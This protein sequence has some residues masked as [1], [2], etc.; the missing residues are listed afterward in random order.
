MFEDPWSWLILIIILA[1]GG[2][3]SLAETAFAAADPIRIKVLSEKSSLAKKTLHLIE[4]FDDSVIVTVIGSN[5][6]SV[7]L[8]TI[9]TIFFITLYQDDSIGTI[10][11]TIFSS[12]LFYIFCDTI[13]KVIGRGLPNQSAL[14]S[15][16]LFQIFKVIFFPIYFILSRIKK[17][18]N[19]STK[20]TS[21]PTMTEA[22][23]ANIV[24]QQ[25]EEGTLDEH[26]VK[27]IQSAI[28]FSDTTVKD[29]LTPI[30]Q[31]SGLP[32]SILH[33]ADLANHL[34]NSPFSRI[35]IYRD[36]LQHIIGVLSIRTY[37]QNFQ[38]NRQVD[39]VL[40]MKKPYFVTSKV[41][42]DD[43]FEGYKKFRTHVAIV[44]DQL[45]HV[46]GMVTMEDVLEEIVGQ[47]EEMVKYTGVIRG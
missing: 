17:V 4:Q 45:G 47:M 5:I 7:L 34:I 11:A 16:F 22:D 32:E 37:F 36:S 46:I 10:I 35:P 25:H 23:F 20:N 30:E 24:E 19:R 3:F 41:T 13:P 12:L 21:Q 14:F 1:F 40:L 18:L 31:M 28:E 44:K 15:T 38:K 8:S 43:L 2:Y 26:E 33:H 27:L 9:S 29:V 39:A 42:I 6:T